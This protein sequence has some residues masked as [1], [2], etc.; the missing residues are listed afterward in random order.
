MEVLVANHGMLLVEWLLG[1]VSILVQGFQ[2]KAIPR[3]TAI[4]LLLVAQRR[5]NEVLEL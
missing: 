1:A 2:A 3:E 4:R 5:G